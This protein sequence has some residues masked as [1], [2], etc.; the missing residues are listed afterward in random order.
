MSR[1]SAPG[2]RRGGRQLGSRNKFS[3]SRARAAIEANARGIDPQD[4]LEMI[5]ATFLDAAEVE[6]RS[7]AAVSQR[8][9][10]DLL[11]KAARVLE[12][13]MPYRYPKLCAIK[14]V[15]D[16]EK[17]FNLSVLSDRELVVMQRLMLKVEAAEQ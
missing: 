1:G 16:P 15:G 12:K 5:A 9:R 11:D 13:L 17:R 2:E 6:A 14:V 10:F 8:R 3:I 7:P 4:M